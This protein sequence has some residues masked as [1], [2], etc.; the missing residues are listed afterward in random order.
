M[1]LCQIADRSADAVVFHEDSA[2]VAF[3]DIA[4]IRPVHT[5][6]IPKQHFDSFDVL[7]SE[8]AG[9][10]TV[11]GATG[12]EIVSSITPRFLVVTKSRLRGVYFAT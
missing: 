2:V 4:P 3:L 9:R 1:F 5:H 11:L 12:S 8:L 10:I 7:P 6:I